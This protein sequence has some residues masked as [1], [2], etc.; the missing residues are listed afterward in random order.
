MI[1]PPMLGPRMRL[2]F[3]IEELRAMALGRSARSSIISTTKDCRAGV[4]NELITPCTSCSAMTSSET[5][6]EAAL[7]R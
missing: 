7:S 1:T 3:T 2:A 6:V 5:R 4:S